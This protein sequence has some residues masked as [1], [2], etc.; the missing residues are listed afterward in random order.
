LTWINEDF[1]RTAISTVG[2]LDLD[3]ILKWSIQA[4][5][6]S[7]SLA[8]AFRRAIAV[9]TVGAE[10][11]EWMPSVNGNRLLFLSWLSELL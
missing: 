2:P 4:G 9:P 11:A 6:L 8:L 7:A 3:R 1:S 10:G 5:Q